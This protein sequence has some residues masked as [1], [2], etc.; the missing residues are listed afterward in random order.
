MNLS[1]KL[2]VTTT[3]IDNPSE[4]PYNINGVRPIRRE[5]KE[6]TSTEIPLELKLS[7]KEPISNPKISK[8]IKR[9][10]NSQN[11]VS[12]PVPMKFT[13]VPDLF[14]MREFKDYLYSND[15]YDVTLLDDIPR[16]SQNPNSLEETLQ[17]DK[18][19]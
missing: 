1:D 2:F 6:L 7:M 11:D 18:K 19:K 14:S 15:I 16:F 10:V 12:E 3:A 9:A 4:L 17:K 13:K 8:R 5:I